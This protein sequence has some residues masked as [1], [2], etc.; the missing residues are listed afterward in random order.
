MAE[1]G[2]FAEFLDW[3]KRKPA[4]SFPSRS[5]PLFDEINAST[6]E[7]IRRIMIADAFSAPSPLYRAFM[8]QQDFKHGIAYPGSQQS[9]DDFICKKVAA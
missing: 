5:K 8:R 3:I 9:L 7:R 2:A 1:A 6:L 4:F